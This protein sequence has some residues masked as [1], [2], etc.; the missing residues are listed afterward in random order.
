MEADQTYSTSVFDYLDITKQKC[1]VNLHTYAH[2]F[3]C[4]NDMT[5][6]KELCYSKG[7]TR[8]G[9]SAIKSL[10]SMNDLDMHQ[11][12]LQLLL[13]S[14]AYHFLFGISLGLHVVVVVR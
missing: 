5:Y 10:Q 12:S 2:I 9:P 7:T 11:W 6:N 1:V 14:T 13:L 4:S 3:I 8:R